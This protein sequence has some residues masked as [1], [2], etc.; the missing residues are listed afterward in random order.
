MSKLVITL[1]L[2]VISYFVLELLLNLPDVIRNIII[3][4]FSIWYYSSYEKKE[5]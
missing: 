5:K 3:L 4:A 2:A 1:A